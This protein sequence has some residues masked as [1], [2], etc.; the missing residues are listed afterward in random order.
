MTKAK[1]LTLRWN[2]ILTLGL[3]LIVLVYAIFVLSTS[4]FSDRAA[5]LGLVFFGVLY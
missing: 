4:A 5:F 1:F 3:G 2:N